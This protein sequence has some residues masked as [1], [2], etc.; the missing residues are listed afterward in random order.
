MMIVPALRRKYTKNQLFIFGFIIQIV[1]FLLILVMAYTNLY[2]PKTW[3]ILCIPGIMIYL[4][5]GMLNVIMTIFL[6]DSVDYGEVKNA[7]RDESVIFSMQTFTVKLASGLAVFLAG[8][9]VDWINLDTTVK[10]QSAKTLTGLRLW[11]TVPAIILLV[12]GIFVYKSR[13]KLDDK[14][15]E[16]IKKQL[17]QK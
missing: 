17:D 15:M 5:Y 8:L 4:G 1:G 12:I 7:T 16:E 2:S 9:V 10:V 13:Y 11:M 14:K 3:F 6:S